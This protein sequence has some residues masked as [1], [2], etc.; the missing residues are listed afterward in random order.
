MQ[1][2]K[3]TMEKIKNDLGIVKRLRAPDIAVYIVGSVLTGIVVLLV[4]IGALAE[5][6]GN[7]RYVFTTIFSLFLLLLIGD[8]VHHLCLRAQCKRLA[9]TGNFLIKKGA[10]KRRISFRHYNKPYYATYIFWFSKY[11]YYELSLSPEDWEKI[12]NGIVI[13]G[14]FRSSEPGDVFYLVCNKR[15]KVLIA[16][17]AKLFEFPEIDG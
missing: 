15:G 6:L 1:K 12:Y 3:L 13:E 2:D 8:C 16:Y 9:A 17:P 11:G 4:T 14:L 7:A 10:L 5:E